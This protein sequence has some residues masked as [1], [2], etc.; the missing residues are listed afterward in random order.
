M[1]KIPL[2]VSIPTERL[3]L[4]RWQPSDMDFFMAMNGDPV[5]ME[6]FLKPLDAAGCQK[7]MGWIENHFSTH[8]FG[9]WA[10][11]GL[12]EREL[13]GMVGCAWFEEPAPFTPAVEVG[14]RFIPSAWGKGYAAEA[15][16]ASMQHVFKNDITAE[17]VAFTAVNNLNSQRVMQKLGMTRKAE[18]DFDHPKV[19]A[20]HPLQRHV[21]YRIKKENFI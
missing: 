17:I 8:G 2:T 7:M 10:V 11:E 12:R 9:F 1:N 3:L 4:R 14:W 19:P 21:L 20:G 5:I 16:R 6:Y 15:A 13:I 18:D